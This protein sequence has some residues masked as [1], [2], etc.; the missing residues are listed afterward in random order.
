MADSSVWELIHQSSFAR[1][2]SAEQCKTISRLATECALQDGEVLIDQGKTDDTLHILAKG[3]LAVERDAGAGETVT[4]HILSS[5][6]LAGELGFV[7]GKEHTATLR[8]VGETT[9]LSLKRSDL[10]SLLATQPEVVYGVMRGIIRTVHRILGKMNL[11]WVELSNY[12]SKTHG[13]Y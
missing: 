1:D 3:R 9:V 7:D 10:E 2:L 5:G 13:R 11:Q 4:L 8:A 12:I 6:D